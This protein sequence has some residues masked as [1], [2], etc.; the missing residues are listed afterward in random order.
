MDLHPIRTAERRV[1]AFSR[2]VA[3]GTAAGVSLVAGMG[4]L[5]VAAWL[6]LSAQGG[7]LFAA[8]VIGL[9][10]LGLGLVLAAVAAARHDP[11]QAGT[12][13][14]GQDAQEVF[15]RMAEGFAAGLEAGRAAREGPHRRG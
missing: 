7:P 4:F 11:P 6:V 10:Y 14:S 12:Q 8:G 9:V 13:R 3:L 5:T 15:V 2:R 1:A